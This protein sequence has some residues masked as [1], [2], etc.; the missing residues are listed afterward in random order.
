MNYTK[1][2]VKLYIILII[3]LNTGRI[4]G[5]DTNDILLVS[6]S[7]ENIPKSVIP[8]VENR[9][10]YSFSE[11]GIYTVIE[12]REIAKIIK[13]QKFSL[14]GLVDHKTAIEAGKLIGADVSAL[15]HMT[16]IDELYYF[17]IKIIDN[18]TSE[19]RQVNHISPASSIVEILN[20]IPS[21]ITQISGVSQSRED[22][23]IPIRKVRINSS[24]F[25]VSTL[26]K[27]LVHSGP[28]VS[29]LSYGGLFYTVGK[30]GEI[31]RWNKYDQGS[32]EKVF[33]YKNWVFEEGVIG[34]DGKNLAVVGLDSVIYLWDT[35]RWGAPYQ[36]IQSGASSIKTSFS[37]HHPSIYTGDSKGQIAVW[38]I[39]YQSVE[40]LKSVS[41]LTIQSLIENSDG[42]GILYATSGGEICLYNLPEKRTWFCE[43]SGARGEQTVLQNHQGQI[44]LSYN[45]YGDAVIWDKSLY[46]SS[47]FIGGSWI[48]SGITYRKNIQ[49]DKKGL[50]IAV[51]A[52]S[53]DLIIFGFKDG[54]LIVF[55]AITWE[56]LV[57]NFDKRP[58]ITAI[59]FIDNQHFITGHIDGAVMRWMIE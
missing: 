5:A 13:E 31:Y 17:D 12:R 34:N 49:L 23:R 28:V 30:K 22:N 39:K 53:D 27:H 42:D 26:N 35:N 38:D 24:V 52:P 4:P 20:G 11:T 51:F 8:V 55:D 45:S 56:P 36:L 9:V 33:Q 29:I 57:N 48:K 21:L 32:A 54:G 6:V 59:N 50:N 47:R 15:V 25:N 2:R 10:I 43:S 41:F 16:F 1:Y 37:G 18:R 40:F 44:L 14:S 58:G 3:I 46:S 19:I 7:S